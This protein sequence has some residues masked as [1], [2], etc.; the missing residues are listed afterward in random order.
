MFYRVKCVTNLF[1]PSPIGG[2]FVFS[3]SNAVGNVW[4]QQLCILGYVCPVGAGTN[5][6]ALWE[7]L[8]PG[9]MS[10]YLCRST[11]TQFF[12]LDTCSLTEY[13]VWRIAPVGTAWT[14]FNYKCQDI[15][16][17]SV[18]AIE[19]VTVPA[20]TFTSCYKF[21][22]EALNSSDPTPYHYDWIKPGF[23][24]VKWVDYWGVA[25]AP[26]VYVLQSWSSSSQ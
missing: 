14:N 3:V 24:E 5:N 15:L 23:G 4:T 6:Y 8:N 16:K 2:Q 25:N 13:P 7:I 20:G 9:S 19:D 12:G 1:V 18:V 11:D 26:D 22:T 21:R 10:L 17:R